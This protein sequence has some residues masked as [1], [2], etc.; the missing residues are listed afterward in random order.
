MMAG[1]VAKKQK[2]YPSS[3]LV[4]VIRRMSPRTLKKARSSEGQADLEH[5]TVKE[6]GHLDQPKAVSDECPTTKKKARTIR[7]NDLS[8]PTRKKRSRPQRT[9]P[10]IKNKR[11][12]SS[13]LDSIHETDVDLQEVDT[14]HTEVCLSNQNIVSIS[15]NMKTSV[16]LSM[17]SWITDLPCRAVDNGTDTVDCSEEA[18]PLPRTSQQKEKSQLA[19]QKQLEDLKARE[20]AVA[21]EERFLRRKGLWVPPCKKNDRKKVT[22]KEEEELTDVHTYSPPSEG[23]GAQAPV[24]DSNSGNS[25]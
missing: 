25:L 4:P 15:P 24:C 8:S 14:Q 20:A 22:W 16:N 17:P 9:H 5:P 11:T 6:P 18:Y 7:T 10:G 1:V 21:R 19:R 3:D 23:S 12:S 13:Y 2:R